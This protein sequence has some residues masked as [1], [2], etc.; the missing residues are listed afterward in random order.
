MHVNV[1][2]KRVKVT[3][4]ELPDGQYGE[5]VSE[6][7]LEIYLKTDMKKRQKTRVLKHEMYHAM[8]WIS[9]ISVALSNDQEEQIVSCFEY[10]ADDIKKEAVNQL[11]GNK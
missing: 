7:E 2:G 5:F 4:K 11:R 9:G 3:E 1:L 10:H 8:L 6:P